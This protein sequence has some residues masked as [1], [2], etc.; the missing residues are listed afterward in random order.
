V[1]GPL[2]TELREAFEIAS[3]S[4]MPPADLADRVRRAVRRRARRALATAAAAAVVLAAAAYLAGTLATG[5]HPRP[6]HRPAPG[7]TI[8]VPPGV[9]VVA[10]AVGGQYIYLATETSGPPP[11]SLSA[12]NRSTGRL[13]RRVNV[14]AAPAVLRVGPGGSVWLMFYANQWGGPSG[15]WLL[16][17]DLA[18]R[19][20]AG[21]GGPSDVLPTGRRTALLGSQYAL[22][23]LTMPPPGEPGH[24]TIHPDPSESVSGRFAAVGLTPI[25]GR[26]AVLEVNDGG[27]SHLVIAGHARL[28]FGG[29]PR[30]QVGYVA[31]EDNALWV[32]IVSIY[33]DPSTGPLLRLSSTL[34][35]ITPRSVLASPVLRRSVQVWS[36]RQTVF[37]STAASGHRLVCFRYNGRMGPVTTI[38]VH[39][40][41]GALATAGNTVYLTLPKDL[42]VSTYLVA[43]P[44]PP[45]CR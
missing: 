12:Y 6:S 16:S 31:A 29:G 26:V 35:P 37:V 28:T 21:F 2:E 3:E 44:I 9:S 10:L 18:R 19:S 4:A 14:P 40:Q 1:S 41:P 36:A 24:A 5:Q 38:P 17:A 11:Y 30:D 27:H 15:T 45:A 22:R 32:T 25:G 13:V 20:S 42:G 39:G 7:L 23:L 34:R 43:R 33:S 8:Q